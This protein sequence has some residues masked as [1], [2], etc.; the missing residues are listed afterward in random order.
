MSINGASLTPDGNGVVT[1]HSTSGDAYSVAMAPQPSGQTCNPDQ[2][3]SGTMTGNLSLSFNCE[4]NM[5]VTVHNGYRPNKIAVYAACP[6]IPFT[7]AER[8]PASLLFSHDSYTVSSSGTSTFSFASFPGVP[9]G[10]VV[11]IGFPGGDADA[12][13][14][15][16]CT[17]VLTNLNAECAQGN[18]GCAMTVY[19]STN[20]T[21][22][23]N[24]IVYCGWLL[25][26]G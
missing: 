5:T 10:A 22:P 19:S 21:G 3:M 12:N 8:G 26:V 7:L 24:A 2:S 18:E 23:I 13:D 11:T 20:V 16:N 17:T 14:I 15:C 6:T 25:H 9:P 4:W 1:M